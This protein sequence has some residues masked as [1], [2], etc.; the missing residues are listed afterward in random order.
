MARRWE[1]HSLS[2][3]SAPLRIGAR[4]PELRITGE[5]GAARVPG[6]AECAP[7]DEDVAE[8]ELA[9]PIRR[10]IHDDIRGGMAR[11]VSLPAAM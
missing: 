1:A 3:R 8:E 9:T 7:D 10:G 5:E 2:M 11:R 6:G 4:C